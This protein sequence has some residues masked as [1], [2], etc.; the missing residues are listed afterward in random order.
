MK[1]ILMMFKL[2]EKLI[3]TLAGAVETNMITES[4]NGYDILQDSGKL[5][6]A[7]GFMKSGNHALIKALKLL[8]FWTAPVHIP[9]GTAIPTGYTHNIFIK[10]D[11]RNIM[12]SVMRIF[13]DASTPEALITSCKDLDYG[14]ESTKDFFELLDKWS[15]WLT[16]PNT[17]VVKFEDLI[18][19]DAEMKRI[20]KYL[21]VPYKVGSFEK[22]PGDTATWN[23]EHTD[24]KDVWTQEVQDL[25][26]SDAGT[27][28]LIKWGYL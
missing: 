24:Y 20:A 17:F 2:F 14:G 6:F 15:G 18:A 27:S 9:F 23:E 21:K 22:L 19:S 12:L 3:K 25:W 16:D 7:H 11:P 26:S 5:V 28:L 8:G 10:R 4:I 1:Y 13:K